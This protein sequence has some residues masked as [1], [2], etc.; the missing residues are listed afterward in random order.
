MENHGYCHPLERSPRIF[1]PTEISI[2][3][4]CAQDTS[5]PFFYT[6][7]RTILL[8][9]VVVEG[10]LCFLSKLFSG[11][12]RTQWFSVQIHSFDLTKGNLP[13]EAESFYHCWKLSHFTTVIGKASSRI[14]PFLQ[15]QVQIFCRP[16]LLPGTLKIVSGVPSSVSKQLS[17]HLPLLF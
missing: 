10:F 8:H 17:L 4:S 15:T 2:F 14:T 3:L 1:R 16:K 6:H 7:L 13:L 9:L 12:L 11:T 5:P